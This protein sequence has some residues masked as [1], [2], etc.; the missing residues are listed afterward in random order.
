MFSLVLLGLAGG[1]SATVLRSGLYGKV[2]RGPIAPV[3]VAEQPCSAPARGSALVFARPDRLSAA[4]VVVR[5]DGFYRVRLAPG[6]Y[7]V[8]SG[9]AIE[10]AAVRVLPNRMRRVDFSID[11]GIR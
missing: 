8:R 10:P 6:R 1:G 7:V 5:A 9:R 2:T 11:T 3:C 4:R